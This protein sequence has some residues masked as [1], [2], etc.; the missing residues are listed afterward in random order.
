MV[1]SGVDGEKTCG[2]GH[3][4]DSVGAGLTAGEVRGVVCETDS[5][6]AG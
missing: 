2:V 5:V 6:W 3:E 1:D 4:G